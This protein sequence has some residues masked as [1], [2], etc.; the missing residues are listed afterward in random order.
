MIITHKGFTGLLV[1]VS[2]VDYEKNEN[3]VGTLDYVIYLYSISIML[4]GET[5]TYEV[6][7]SELEIILRG[8]K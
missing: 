2:I 6:T 4:N 3:I 1:N 8:D 5:R 7:P